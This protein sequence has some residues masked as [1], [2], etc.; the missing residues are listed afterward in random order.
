MQRNVYLVAVLMFSLLLTQCGKNETWQGASKQG[1]ELKES[2][3]KLSMKNGTFQ[4][5]L[6]VP[7]GTCGAESGIKANPQYFFSAC[8]AGELRMFILGEQE[9]EIAN[10]SQVLNW[11]T[12]EFGTYAKDLKYYMEEKYAVSDYLIQQMNIASGNGF[13]GV[14]FKLKTSEGAQVSVLVSNVSEG[15]R[16]VVDCFG[17]CSDESRDCA[18]RWV[19]ATPPYAE[20]TCQGDDCRMNVWPMIGEE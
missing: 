19:M 9:Q 17:S 18:E 4:E 5:Y 7:D 16:N 14:I 8:D 1:V 13:F 3:F 2:D 10:A 12:S 6:V 20:C 15:I 11:M